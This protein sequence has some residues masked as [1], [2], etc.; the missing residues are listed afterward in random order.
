LALI[1]ALY[2]YRIDDSYKATESA[3]R[4]KETSA[5]ALMQL[6]SIG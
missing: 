2:F 5:D 6:A 1:G 4:M 3:E